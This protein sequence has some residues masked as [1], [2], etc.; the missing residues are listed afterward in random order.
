MFNLLKTSWA[1]I[2]GSSVHH[3]GESKISR[4]AFRIEVTL[5]RLIL[6][7]SHECP[8]STIMDLKR[9]IVQPS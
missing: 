5:K 8:K 9:A 7:S 1:Q 4:G 2:S 6:G 3:G